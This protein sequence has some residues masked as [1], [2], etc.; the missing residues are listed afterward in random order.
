M[1][2]K[3]KKYFDDNVMYAVEVESDYGRHW[4]H[5]AGRN[6]KSMLDKI[7]QREDEWLSDIDYCTSQPDE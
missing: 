6:L 4:T 1:A 5:V 7:E 3:D 2:G